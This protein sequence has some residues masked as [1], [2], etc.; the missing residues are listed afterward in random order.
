MTFVDTNIA[1]C[2]QKICQF[3]LLVYYYI[4]SARVHFCQQETAQVRGC[5]SRSQKC[6]DPL[7]LLHLHII[8]FSKILLCLF[9]LLLGRKGSYS[10]HSN[11]YFVKN[12]Y[13]F[14][15]FY[16]LMDFYLATFNW[17]FN[18]V[19]VLTHIYTQIIKQ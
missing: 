12:S 16:Y 19:L 13:K 1:N 11:S 6:S 4:I 9:L 14:I 3:F 2:F 18:Y 17:L 10:F 8:A 5:Y 15:V 7:G